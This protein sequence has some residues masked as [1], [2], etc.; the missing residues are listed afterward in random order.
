PLFAI[1]LVACWLRFLW[2]EQH[3]QSPRDRGPELTPSSRMAVPAALPATRGPASR[4]DD[5]DDELAAYNAYLTQLAER[6]RGH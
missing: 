5:A 4:E 1:V 3:P 2:L 6:D